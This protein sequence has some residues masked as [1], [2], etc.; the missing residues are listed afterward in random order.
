MNNDNYQ[1]VHSKIWRPPRKSG[2]TPKTIKARVIHYAIIQSP[3]RFSKLT[4]SSSEVFIYPWE[5]EI[6]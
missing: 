3:Q 4:H 5:L 1:I 2:L 6:K